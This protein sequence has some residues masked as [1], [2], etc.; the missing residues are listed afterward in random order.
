[1]S[2]AFDQWRK[3]FN[4]ERIWFALL[5]TGHLCL[6]SLSNGAWQRIRNQR[7]LHNVEDELLA[8]LDQEA[9]LF[10]GRKEAVEQVYLFA[11]EHPGLVLPGD[12]G[13]QVVSLQNEMLAPLH[14]PSA[15]MT[16]GREN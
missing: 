5:E 11:P 10:S 14:Y 7:I 6:A 13:W 3:R 15:V 8:A 9:I 12:C 4:G 2:A 16:P 1:L